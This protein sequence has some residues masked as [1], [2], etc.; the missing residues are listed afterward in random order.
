MQQRTQPGFLASE[1]FNRVVFGSASGGA[2][3]RR[4]RNPST[5]S[6]ATRWWSSI[7][8]HYVPDHAAI[9]FAGDITL[10]R[11]ASWSS[12][13]SG[14]EEGGR[15][16][17]PRCR[18]RR[19]IGRAEGVPVARPGSVQTTLVVGTQSMTRTDPDYESADRRQPR[20]RRHDGPA[21]PAPARGEGLHLR[22]RQRVL[23]A[24][25]L[26]SAPGP[27]RRR[28][29]TEV[30]EPALNDLLAEIAEMRDK[31]V[32]ADELD[33]A[34]RAIVGGFALSISRA[35]S[36]CSATTSTT[37]R[38]AC[39]R[40]TG[41]RIRRGSGGHR[42]G[43]AGRGAEVLGCLRACRSWRSATREDH[44]DPAEE[45]SA[46]DL[47]RRRQSDEVARL[48]TGQQLTGRRRHSAPFATISSI[49]AANVSISSSVV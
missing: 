9:A 29:R 26:S 23:G 48:A 11:R 33:D 3:V 4:R 24:T 5:P 39:R 36:R 1:M 6:R 18:I 37:G 17:S 32:P 8:T 43:G 2:R 35:R 27:R 20:A 42:G 10:P 49:A 45:G 13:S 28:V 14:L 31:P 25:Q 16:R 47:R 41:T 46:R 19:A 21:V 44:R 7:S 40:T 38:T 12:R 22:H 30:T 34:K 15:R